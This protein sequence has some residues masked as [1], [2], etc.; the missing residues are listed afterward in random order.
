[1]ITLFII[2]K[3]EIKIF[4]NDLFGEVRTMV[5][6]KGEPFFVGC[7]VAKA[8]GYKNQADA[9]KRHVDDEDKGVVKRDTLGGKQSVVIINESGLYALVLSSKL[10]QAKEFKRWVTSEVLPQIRQTGGYIP[11]RNARTGEALTDSE[12]VEVAN[13]IMACTIS[14]ANLPADD[15]F[16]ASQVAESLDVTANILNHFLVDKG[17]QY[18]NGSRYKLTAKYSDCG[19]AEERQFYYYALNGDKK[20][21]AYL[22]WT[23]QGKDFIKSIFH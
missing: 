17:I 23:P 18:W 11:T 10:P 1:M 5:D 9:L 22:V 20:Q 14:R 7:D 3:Q 15:C 6:E 16:T 19:Y 12:M 8:L 13:K 2:M 21:R 4:K